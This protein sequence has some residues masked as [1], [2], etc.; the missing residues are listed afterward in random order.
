LAEKSPPSAE[1]L[2][3]ALDA[4][5]ASGEYKRLLRYA[6]YRLLG[7]KVWVSDTDAT[8]L[9]N[10][11]IIRTL[12]GKR[13]WDSTKHPLF[14][15]LLGCVNSMA[16]G[17]FKQAAKFTELSDVHASKER[18]EPQLEAKANI[19]RLRTRL[20]GDVV[21]LKVLETLLDGDS[22]MEAQKVLK[23]PQFVY[24]AARKRIYRQA[25]RLFGP[26]KDK[27]R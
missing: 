19:E 17:R 7:V 27:R 4:L 13:I 1:V 23:I 2:A 18:I 15:H 9:A 24:A 22:P 3:A 25:K 12:E 26:A 21:G 14:I 6:H 16:N 8:D 5:T 20:R 10:E 11:A